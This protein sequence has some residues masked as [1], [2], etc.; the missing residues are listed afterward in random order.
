MG[1]SPVRLA[2]IAAAI[3]LG[4]CTLAAQN[5]P[6]EAPPLKRFPSDL[7][8]NFVGLASTDNLKPLLYGGLLTG[9]AAIPEQNI[10]TYF[11]RRDE[12]FESIGEPGEY[13]GDAR[14]IGASLGTAFVVS[15]LSGG[16][17]FQRT[18]YE[19]AQGLVINGAI[20]GATKKLVGRERPNGENHNSFPSGHTSTAF[21]WATVLQRNYGWKLGVPAYLTASYIGATR[22][23]E[24][25]HHLT[26]VFAGATIGYIVGRTVTRSHHKGLQRF[27]WNVTPVRGGAVGG[28]AIQLGRLH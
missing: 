8:K 17:R 22:L 4:T 2:A 12:A 23:E 1:A 6:I 26:D 7:A 11:K 10:E 20:T 18:T 13:L 9:A 25:A 14:L 3:W 27:T 19:I 15:R 5:E 24:N 28:V 16:P 21:T